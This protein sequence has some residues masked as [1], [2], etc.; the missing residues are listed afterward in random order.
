[1]SLIACTGALL[2]ALSGRRTGLLTL[3]P[4]RYVGRISYTIYLIHFTVFILARATAWTWCIA[5]VTFV[6][7]L[8]Y[9]AL[10]WVVLER[11]ILAR[12]PTS[13]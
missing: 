1:M 8:L 7:T 13:P 12:R 11:P 10:S 5:G 4:I 2:W 6:A 9:A 3:S